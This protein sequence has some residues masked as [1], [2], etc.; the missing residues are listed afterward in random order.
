[1]HVRGLDVHFGLLV[2][3]SSSTPKATSKFMGR[4]FWEVIFRWTPHPAIVTIRKKRDYIRVL[5][6]SY[7]IAITGWGVLLR[8]SLFVFRSLLD[9]TLDQG[10]MLR[11]S[12]RKVWLKVYIGVMLG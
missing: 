10:L 1:M 4:N 2:G 12:G 7:Y 11:S 8:C 9:Q 6:Y 3:C 5:L